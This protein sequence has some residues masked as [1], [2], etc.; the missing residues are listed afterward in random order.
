MENGL[1]FQ[2]MAWG[3]PLYLFVS[4]NYNIKKKKKENFFLFAHLT[5][6]FPLRKPIRLNISFR[7]NMTLNDKN[8]TVHN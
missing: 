5:T 1:E 8:K 7:Q 6:V 2:L 3:T 4:K